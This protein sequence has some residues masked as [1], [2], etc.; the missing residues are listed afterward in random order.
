MVMLTQRDC[1]TCYIYIV[2]IIF[3]FIYYI[4]VMTNLF[5]NFISSANMATLYKD[6]A[7]IKNLSAQ[8]TNSILFSS[9]YNLPNTLRNVRNVAGSPVKLLVAFK[10]RAN[11]CFVIRS[12]MQFKWYRMG[13]INKE[14]HGWKSIRILG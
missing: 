5:F 10:Q 9:Y 7:T 8:I 6:G 4:I 1:F 13:W 11:D 2:I 3:W 12:N 14:W